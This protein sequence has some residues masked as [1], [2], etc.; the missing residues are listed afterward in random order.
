MGTTSG[1]GSAPGAREKTLASR[2][3]AGKVAD[4]AQLA[5]TGESDTP[6]VPLLAGWAAVGGGAACDIYATVSHSPDL[7]REANP[8]IRSLLDNGV[9]LGRVYGYAALTQVL[10]V[11]VTMVLWLG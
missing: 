8:L 3:G 1:S 7:S 10:F 5:G 11:A 4:A 2:E 6:R 9:S